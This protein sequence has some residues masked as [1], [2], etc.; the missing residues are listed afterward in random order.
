MGSFNITRAASI[1]ALTGG[2]SPAGTT[3]GWFSSAGGSTDDLLE[4]AISSG[5]VLVYVSDDEGVVI[6]SISLGFDQNTPIFSLDGGPAISFNSL[7]SG[8]KVLG[9]SA[10]WT[11]FSA[12]G[13]IT[14]FIGFQ[15]FNLFSRV[16]QNFP[17][18]AGFTGLSIPAMSALDF[19]DLEFKLDF[20]I[21]TTGFV[22]FVTCCDF[23]SFSLTGTYSIESFQYTL[24]TPVIAPTTGDVITI[25]SD[26]KNPL[27]LKLD[28]IT[29]I[30][31]ILPDLTVVPVTAIVTSTLSEFFLQFILPDIITSPI[32]TIQVV[33]NGTQF[34]GSIDLGQLI[35]IFFLNGTGIYKL[36]P[37]KTNDTLYVQDLDPVQTIDVKIPTPFAKTGFLP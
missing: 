34:S 35:T 23:T 28:D 17:S 32:I 6:G 15:L 18:I 30:N 8:F 31:I 25:T 12:G 14:D 22:S 36:V 26:P 19:I 16:Q 9:A 24:K 21:D 11:F 5:K 27:H 20:S 29:T 7:P 13:T 4:Q 33:G 2:R 1:S 37:G 3:E 10:S